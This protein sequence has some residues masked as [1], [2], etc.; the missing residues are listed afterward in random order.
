[1]K[2]A[3]PSMDGSGWSLKSKTDVTTKML[4]LFAPSAKQHVSPVKLK[5]IN[6]RNDETPITNLEITL[7]AK[8]VG[9]DVRKITIFDECMHA[10]AISLEQCTSG[11]RTEAAASK[12]DDALVWA[13]P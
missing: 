7:D 1:M 6:K 11:M 4:N 5:T 8:T 2:L 9:K 13:L 12:V 3:F 10:L